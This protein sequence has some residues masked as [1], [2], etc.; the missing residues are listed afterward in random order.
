M[1]LPLTINGNESP[2]RNTSV[3]NVQTQNY[4]I[5]QLNN[6]II[7]RSC[8]L[9]N[10]NVPA[11]TL[12]IDVKPGG[13]SNLN[14][15]VTAIN[16]LFISDINHGINMTG[17]NIQC[18]INANNTISTTF[19]LNISS[20]IEENLYSVY[21][22]DNYLI[23]NQYSNVDISGF[24]G[25]IT[26][27]WLV[28][29]ST[30]IN[31][32]KTYLDIPNQNYNLFTI[33]NSVTY[34]SYGEVSG[35]GTIQSKNITLIDASTNYFY[36]RPIYDPSGGV[37][38]TEP[39]S[40][41]TAGYNDI[42]ITIPAN[43]YSKEL[44]T[45]YINSA[46]NANPI[47]Q[48]SRL[49]FIIDSNTGKQ[50]TKLRLN[51]SKNFTT[52]DFILDFYD[53]VS[54]TTCNVGL[55]GKS[56][57]QN[58]QWDETL[59]WILGFR[60]VTNYYLKPDNQIVNITTG[61]TYYIQFPSTPYSYDYLGNAKITGD[62]SVSVFL[63]NYFMIILDDYVQNH[64][65]DGLVTITNT[66]FN[67]PLPSYANR[68]TFICD[69]ITHKPVVITNTT[70]YN[71]L[72]QKQIYA[73][74]EILNVQQ[75]NQTHYSSGPFTQDIFGLVPI[76]VSGM[77]NG[78]PYIEFGGSLQLQERTYFG[79]V[80]IRRMTIK[81]VNDKGAIVDLNGANWS[82]SLVCEQLYSS[83]SKK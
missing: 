75:T 76:K 53:P 52:K 22:Y 34:L 50:Y 57:I 63:Y 11:I 23:S 33:P 12:S 8:G 14:D 43:T 13:Y 38:T 24:Y 48:G 28:D 51:I 9:Q 16:K 18:I 58:V 71:S 74:N 20:L 27:N 31:T 69:P 1:K 36:I 68:A 32:W 15:L 80:N 60:N 17:T 79:P 62:T 42:L 61:K 10:K 26:K 30:N 5:D 35:N 29:I 19:T 82:F 70:R 66:D 56:S 81:L 55:S 7:I 39:N 54:F 78:Q 40:N 72:T 44:F 59:G 6:K 21:L 37:Y 2:A 4:Q 45:T 77:Q 41:G 65:N 46:F 3:F 47:T 64:L 67:I 25:P 83:T 49:S 73:A